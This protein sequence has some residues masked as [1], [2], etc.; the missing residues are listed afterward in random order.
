MKQVTQILKVAIVAALLAYIFRRQATFA[1][2]RDVLKS[3]RPELF[4]L[5]LALFLLTKLQI[6]VRLHVVA[7]HVRPT[8]LPRLLRDVL[9]AN[10]F[11][12]VLP[13]GSGEVYRIKRLAGADGPLLQSAA[14][15]VLDRA[16]GLFAL[17]SVG[18]AALLFASNRIHILE[19]WVLPALAATGLLVFLAIGRFLRRRRLESNV[20]RSLKLLFRY[21]HEQP[22]EAL[23]VYAGSILIIL[24][25]TVAIYIAAR[26]IGMTVALRDFL[27]LYPIVLVVSLIP[28]TVGGL[29]LRELAN[30]AVFGT[31][32]V[33]KAHCVS[34]GLVQYGM[35]LVVATVGLAL[36]LSG[37][38]HETFVQSPPERPPRESRSK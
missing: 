10:F 23:A 37:T 2:V 38:L 4:L 3:M 24:T 36:L 35:M 30:I 9:V 31:L 21:V 32:G 26:G 18:A 5:G 33:S 19:P 12:T 20:G 16:F 17:L 34:L 13:M 14:V 29:G 7:A 27:S 28:I 25:L 1:A 22:V 15:I 8:P 6:A 11:N